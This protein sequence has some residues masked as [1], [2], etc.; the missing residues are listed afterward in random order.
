MIKFVTA[1]KDATISEYYPSGNMGQSSLLKIGRHEVQGQWYNYR[2]LLGIDINN[3]SKSL[4]TINVSS[5]VYK[6]HLFDVFSKD[7]NQPYDYYIDIAPIDKNTNWIE[8][9][10]IE[11]NGYQT[12]ASNWI[13]Y[14]SLNY[15]M[16]PGGDYDTSLSASLYVENGSEDLNVDITNMVYQ[17]F[18]TNA[19]NGFLLKLRNTYEA[20]ASTSFDTKMF[21]SKQSSTIFK[22]RI[23]VMY[24]DSVQD[25]K[26]RMLLG[27]NRNNKIYFY[28]VDN[29]IVSDFT[30]PRLTEI[31]F[32]VRKSGSSLTST[33]SILL[34]G[35]ASRITS[36]VFTSS[37]INLT[38]SEAYYSTS[39]FVLSWYSGSTNIFSEYVEAHDKSYVSLLTDDNLIINCK[40]LKKEY[41]NKSVARF[42][43]FLRERYPNYAFSSG[44]ENLKSIIL[45]NMWY[46]VRD[47]VDDNENYRIV[48]FDDS[49]TKIS[50][51]VSGN[52]F[53]LD[54]SIFNINR[55]YSV[56]LK[57][58]INDQTLL[59]NSAFTFLVK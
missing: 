48:P 17:M 21:Y 44:N 3:I 52:Y 23:E 10:G 49:C 39:K 22:P 31:Y 6:L 2:S 11:E 20:L 7:G 19:N 56:D 46:S 12:G 18:S 24:D 35:T 26:G 32:D 5:P 57:Y 43:L 59:M 55:V 40:N 14:D 33:S 15:W 1:S 41:S 25:D 58:K 8:G 47:Y 9:H 29:G 51:N 30:N 27:S 42:D 45:P 34:N 54:M 53:N 50:Y 13:R 28:N 38:G 4:S 16:N 36:G 37:N